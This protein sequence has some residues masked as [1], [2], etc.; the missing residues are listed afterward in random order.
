MTQGARFQG[1]WRHPAFVKLWLGQTI[2]VFGS[3]VS[4]FAIP[5]LAVVTLDASPLAVALLS[6]AGM[7]PGFV[8]GL[9]AG[10]WIDR[11]RRR[12]VLVATDIGRAAILITIPIAAAFDSLTIGHLLVAAF[13]TSILSTFFD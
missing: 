2:S 4:G 10:V 11:L 6:A 12:P 1:L 7:A 9:V 13:A 8:L 5:I 3:F